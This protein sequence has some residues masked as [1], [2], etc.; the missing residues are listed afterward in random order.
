MDEP[1]ETEFLRS[2]G[3]RIRVTLSILV[4]GAWLCFLVLYLFFWAGSYGHSV[5]EGLAVIM[6]SLIVGVVMTAL[7]WAS[8]GLKFAAE[9]KAFIEERIDEGMKRRI[10]EYIDKRMDEKLKKK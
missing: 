8:W 1:Q 3:F 2:P 9:H 6:V 10:D 7:L 4:W 5:L